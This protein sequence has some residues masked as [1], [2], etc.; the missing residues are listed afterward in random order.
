MSS[1]I[2]VSSWKQKRETS[3]RYGKQWKL[4]WSPISSKGRAEKWVRRVSRTEGLEASFELQTVH[5]PAVFLP[6]SVEEP[7]P[8]RWPENAPSRAAKRLL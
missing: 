8:G 7:L 1:C 3:L 5:S 6:F 2:Y 4:D